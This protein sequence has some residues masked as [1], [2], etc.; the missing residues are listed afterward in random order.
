MGAILSRGDSQIK[1]HI[2]IPRVLGA[3]SMRL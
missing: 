2:S 3:N 1:S